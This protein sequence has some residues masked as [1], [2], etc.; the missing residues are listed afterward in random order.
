MHASKL[1]SPVQMLCSPSEKPI[2]IAV[3]CRGMSII[4]V[5][6]V[7]RVSISKQACAMC[8]GG[9]CSLCSMLTR[10]CMHLN[11]IRPLLCENPCV[12]RHRAGEGPRVCAR[13]LRALPGVGDGR[14]P[15]PD[16][17]PLLRAAAGGLALRGPH[18][19]LAV[20]GRGARVLAAVLR[21]AGAGARAR[22]HTQKS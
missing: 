9:Q 1:P 17:L 2:V 12:I 20:V 10:L 15:A 22:R 6:V 21:P 18:G 3:S 16:G 7:Q 14:D 5:C 11:A 13:Q 4:S 19:A 8:F